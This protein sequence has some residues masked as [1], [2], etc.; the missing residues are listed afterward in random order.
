METL[1]FCLVAIMIAGYVV[2]DGYDIGAGIMHMLI[3]RTD[4]DR[5][6]VL[7]SIGPLWDGNEVWLLAAGGTLY[8]AFPALYAASFSGFYLPLMMVL[9]LL[10]L[11]GIS[12]EFRSHIHNAVWRPFW[13]FGFAFSSI[14]LAIFFGAALAN[15]VRGVPLDKSGF[16]FLPL[17][18]DFQ[19]GRAIG[20]LDWYTVLVGIASLSTLSLHGATWLAY[21]TEGDLHARAKGAGQ[22]FWW[23]VAGMTV[24]V[25]AISFAIQPHLNE[26]FTSHPWG[27]VF[28]AIAVAGLIG[29]RLFTAMRQDAKAFLSSAIYIV[30]MLTS[31]CF[32]VY[33]Y[34]LPAWTDKANGLTVYNAAAGPYGLSI[35]LVWWAI[36]MALAVGYTAYVHW[37][38]GGKVRLQEE[39]GY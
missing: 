29:V 25:T 11:R 20:I 24:V 28:P 14:L 32:G 2:L 10:I 13:D 37:M 38:F 39:E 23:A 8:F 18:T 34:V 31:V 36:G 7:K 3:A 27:Y 1:W 35:G 9:W 21:K 6:R 30:G 19:L 15:V 5:R 4:Q 12:I 26:Q 22:W 17:W 16:F 33:P